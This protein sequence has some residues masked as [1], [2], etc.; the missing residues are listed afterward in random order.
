MAM[1]LERTRRAYHERLQRRLDN[2]DTTEYG[3]ASELG[4]RLFFDPCGPTALYGTRANDWRKMRT[5]WK[6]LAVDPDKPSTLLSELKSTETGCRF[7]LHHWETLRGHLEPGGFWSGGDRLRAIRMIGQQPLDAIEDRRVAEIFAAS[8][9]IRPAHDK[10][11]EELR[12]DMPFTTLDDYVKKLNARWT[13]LVRPK[14]REKARQILIDLVDENVEEIEAIL[15]RLAQQT[16]EV[17]ARGSLDRVSHDSSREA[18]SMRRNWVRFK[19]GFQRG[20]DAL[21]KCRKDR[22]GSGEKA[23]ISAEGGGRRAEERRILARGER[24]CTEEVDASDALACQGFIP[25]RCRDGLSRS[26]AEDG[27]P[28]TEEIDIADGNDADLASQPGTA[29][30]GE[31][32]TTANEGWEDENVANEPKFVNDVL[33]SQTQTNV[34][35]AADSGH[36]SGLDKYQFSSLTG[37][38]RRS[39]DVER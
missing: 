8:F 4:D 39:R 11:F 3:T 34:E 30:C 1:E 22:T 12:S 25:D 14:E 7:L 19:N 37:V 24:P 17:K 33:G 35:V 10:P 31:S 5:S 26:R 2:A 38:F 23:G 36:D 9:A 27:R 21:R 6:S 18:E 28:K 16:L 13:D 20:K 15:E 32:V 29:D